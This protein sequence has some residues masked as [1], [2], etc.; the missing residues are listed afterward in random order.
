[1]P[2]RTLG[3]KERP[4]GPVFTPRAPERAETLTPHSS[5]TT[6]GSPATH[7]PHATHRPRAAPAGG[8]EEAPALP[9]TL[10]LAAYR[11]AQES[12]TNVLR[13]AGPCAQAEMI[14][15]IGRRKMLIQVDDDGRGRGDGRGDHSPTTRSFREGSGTGLAG[16]RERA[17]TFG[18]KVRA[19]PRLDHAGWRVRV[20]LPITTGER[21]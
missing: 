10:E 9:P 14:V 15:V 8:P 1:M 21:P 16:M 20:I 6:H 17:A 19:G 7:E 11:I 12:L 2:Q 5:Q 18:G 3:A 13:H 4:N